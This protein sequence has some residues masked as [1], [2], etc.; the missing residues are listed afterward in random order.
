MCPGEGRGPAY[1][2][3]SVH[4]DSALI[5]GTRLVEW[6]G[7]AMY[8]LW[9]AAGTELYILAALAIF[10][11]GCGSINKEQPMALPRNMIAKDWFGIS[12]LKIYTMQ[13]G[14]KFK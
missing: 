14:A 3:G 6:T 12:G 9:P 10:Y 13:G 5:L 7:T 4:L 2:R 11:S 8:T 1:M